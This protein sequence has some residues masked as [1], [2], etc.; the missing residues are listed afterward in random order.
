MHPTHPHVTCLADLVRIAAQRNPA[1]IAIE[2]DH[3]RLAYAT[4]WERSVRLANAIRARG[5]QPGDRVAVFA[6]NC[7]AYLET[8][9]GLQLAGVVA[10]PATTGSRRPSSRT[11]STTPARRR[12]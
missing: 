8:Y 10:V 12:C 6:Q 7:P 5:L 11:C 9:V 3:G 2:H 1:A 4:F